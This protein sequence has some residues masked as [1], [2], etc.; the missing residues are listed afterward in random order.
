MNQRQT[1]NSGKVIP[2][3]E[4]AAAIKPGATDAS[5]EDLIFDKAEV[6][7]ETDE[8][9]SEIDSLKQQID[10]QAKTR[11]TLSPKQQQQLEINLQ[12]MEKKK[13]RLTDELTSKE[14]D[15]PEGK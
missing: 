11:K 15:P 13:Q 7:A 9:R 3:Q 6:A 14:L 2:K 5:P 1:S 8:L 12:Q 10:E 4:I